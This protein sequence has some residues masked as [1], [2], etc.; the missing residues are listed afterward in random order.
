MIYGIGMDCVEI[1]RMQKSM[2]SQHFQRRVFSEEER[3]L[4][5][6]K[7][8]Q[9]AATAAV[10]FA[11]K[12]AFLKACGRGLSGFPLAE[13]SALRKESGAPYL[14]VSGSAASFCQEQGLLCHLSLC[15]EGGLA[16]AYVVLEK[17][18]S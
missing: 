7:G 13:I 16:F 6:Q 8:R 17:A 3:A 5:P 11:A 10:C 4:F 12:E 18:N 9:A 2:E 15:H 14:H 1:A